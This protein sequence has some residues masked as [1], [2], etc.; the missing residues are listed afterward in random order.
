MFGNIFQQQS[1]KK[2]NW[3]T[4]GK[5]VQTFCHLREVWPKFD[6]IIDNKCQFHKCFMKFLPS[7]FSCVFVLLLPSV[8]IILN[9]TKFLFMRST[10]HF[11]VHLQYM[12]YIEFVVYSFFRQSSNF[13]FFKAVLERKQWV[14]KFTLE[15]IENFSDFWHHP[16]RITLNGSKECFYNIKILFHNMKI[17]VFIQFKCG[18]YRNQPGEM[19]QI[20]WIPFKTL[21]FL[22]LWTWQHFCIIKK[23]ILRNKFRAKMFDEILSILLVLQKICSLFPSSGRIIANDKILSKILQFDKRLSNIFPFDKILSNWR[24]REAIL[25]NPYA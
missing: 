22:V 18:F 9:E 14:K 10:L 3:Q 12:W 21:F 5:I 8:C 24:N 13:F 1:A 25:R 2:T 17:L 19:K 20:I 16:H 15:W 23:R 4:F 6:E 11:S 7:F